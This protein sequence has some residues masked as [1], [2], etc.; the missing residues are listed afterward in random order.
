MI[1]TGLDDDILKSLFAD[2]K[3]FF[4]SLPTIVTALSVARATP[5]TFNIAI[6]EVIIILPLRVSFYFRLIRYM[7]FDKKLKEELNI[8]SKVFL[9]Y[10]RIYFNLIFIK[11]VVYL[12]QSIDYRVIE[13]F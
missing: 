11:T 2:L 9:G 3:I 10:F 12:H 5:S 6:S 7:Y 1:P 8:V 4:P 13:T